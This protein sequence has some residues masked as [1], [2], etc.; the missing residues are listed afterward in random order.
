MAA[1][2]YGR[3]NIASILP[4][5]GADPNL[6]GPQYR[7]CPL[8]AAIEQYHTRI[9]TLLLKTK[10]VDV[11]ARRFPRE[12]SAKTARSKLGTGVGNTTT[13]AVE[14]RTELQGAMD[15]DTTIREDI[16]QDNGDS[17]NAIPGVEDEYY[18]RWM[19]GR[20]AESLVYIAAKSDSLEMV[21]ALLE[22]GADPNIQ[23]GLECTALQVACCGG[24]AEIVETLLQHGA[25][26]NIC[27]GKAGSPLQAACAC[28]SLRIVRILLGVSV[29]VNYVDKNFSV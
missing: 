14:S 23:G 27:G 28:P 6:P 4:D 9:V 21:N 17:T 15:D 10:G 24:S 22:A 11:N 8:A 2:V 16:H 12:K 25:N 3:E 5:N 29:D 18:P 19:T 1:C 20:N 26:V 7:G 13:N